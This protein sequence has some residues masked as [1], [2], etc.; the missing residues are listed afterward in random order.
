MSALFGLGQSLLLA[1][2]PERAHDL[3][4]KSLELGL[5]PRAEAPDDTRLAQNLFGLDFPNPLGMAAGFDKN[6]RVPRELLAMGF[7]FVEVGTLTPRAQSGNPSPRMFR[8]LPDRAVINRLGFNNE[9]Q[10]AAL[11]RLRQ[12]RPRGIVGV[13][14]GAGRDSADRIGD[15]VTGIARMAEVASYFTVNISS[16]NTPGLRDLQAPEALDALLKRVQDARAALPRKPPPL[17]VKLAPDIAEVDLPEIVP[18]ILWH[19]AD[20]IV[21]S[22]TTLARAGLRDHAFARETGGLSGRPLFARATRML[23]RV[24]QL[25]EGKL[26]L[27][28]VGGIDSGET[29]LAKIE[30][31]ASLLQLYTG[32]VFEG[33]SLIG[34]IKQALIGAIEK[35]GNTSLPPLIGKRAGEWAEKAL[36]E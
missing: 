11:V 12:D 29:A 8:S 10:E 27:I 3:A 21:V 19:G 33:P 17:L 4:I 36:Q 26:P 35:S 25:T 28:G 22:N 20:G 18:V 14:L 16:P 2:P 6:A 1:L 15:Y 30:A 24:Y 5:Y 31:G 13:N 32:L 9:G 34:R 23:A 7:G